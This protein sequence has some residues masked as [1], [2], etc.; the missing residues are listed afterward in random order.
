MQPRWRDY[1][2]IPWSPGRLIGYPIT[3]EV[4]LQHFQNLIDLL[5]EDP[6]YFPAMPMYR[7]CS[8]RLHKI[9]AFATNARPN[10]KSVVSN[11]TLPRFPIN[12]EVCFRSKDA[13][14][15]THLKIKLGDLNAV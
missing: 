15:A 3:F 5:E 14:M 2:L 10:T 4:P 8:I 11:Q 7:G 12:I 1:H 6:D 13:A 9:N